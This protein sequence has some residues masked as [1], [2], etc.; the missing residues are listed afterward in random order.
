MMKGLLNTDEEENI[1]ASGKAA[2]FSL[3]NTAYMNT[4]EEENILA[5]CTHNPWAPFCIRSDKGGIKH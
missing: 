5:I 3:T 2:Q 4:D 1:L